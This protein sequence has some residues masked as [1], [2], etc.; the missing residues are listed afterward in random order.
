[1]RVN[2][3]E[4]DGYGVPCPYEMVSQFSSPLVR[5]APGKLSPEWERV[6]R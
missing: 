4:N 2:L 1:M 6:A 5:A 3:R